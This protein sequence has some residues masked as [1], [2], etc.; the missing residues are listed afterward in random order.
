MNRV[1]QLLLATAIS[2]AVAQGV[3]AAE[4]SG[5]VVDVQRYPNLKIAIRSWDPGSPVQTHRRHGSGSCS[6]GGAV[7]LGLGG[8]SGFYANVRCLPGRD[9]IAAE[10]EI[11]PDRSNT[12]IPSSQSEIDL[13][14]MRSDFIEV[15]KDDNGRVYFLIIEPEIAIAKKPTKFDVAQLA[16]YDWDFPFSPVVLND[17]VYVG[18]IGMSGGSVAG[19]EIAGVANLEF[20]LLPITDAKPIG[21]LQGGILKIKTDEFEVAVSGVRNGAAKETL[22]GPFKV[23]V[24]QLESSGTP[25]ELQSQFRDQIQEL[26]KR[27]AD[28]D[29]SITDEVIARIKGFI[30]TGRPMLLGSSARDV[31]KNEIS[32]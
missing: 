32:E 11:E 4:S 8:K 1:N 7:R 6:H 16:P 25:A 3:F 31:R 10:V 27:Q 12:S 28:G 20:S 18:R 30:A 2:V 22:D 9:R 24:R 13:S 17:E 5:D 29:S 15:T 19:I 14:D 21:N 23:W 26:E